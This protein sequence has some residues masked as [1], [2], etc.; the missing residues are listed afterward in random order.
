EATFMG[1]KELG[2]YTQTE[3]DRWGKVVKA[4]NITAN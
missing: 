1:P 4:A 2:A 3:L